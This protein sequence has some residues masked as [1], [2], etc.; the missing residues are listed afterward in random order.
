MRASVRLLRVDTVEGYLLYSYCCIGQVSDLG[1][2]A[3]DI[4]NLP[5]LIL[6]MAMMAYP[7]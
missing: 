4:S 6:D 1:S 2:Y 3:P 5:F 7:Q